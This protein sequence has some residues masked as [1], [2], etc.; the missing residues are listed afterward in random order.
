MKNITKLIFVTL[1]LSG[2]VQTMQQMTFETP[3]PEQVKM[4][5]ATA[6]TVL[7]NQ[8]QGD[9]ITGIKNLIN[10]AFTSFEATINEQDYPPLNALIVAAALPITTAIATV[11]RY[12]EF[13]VDKIQEA[14]LPFTILGQNP[15]LTQILNTIIV[16]NKALFI[17]VIGALHPFFKTLQATFEEFVQN[18]S[19]LASKEFQ[20]TVLTKLVKTIRDQN[21]QQGIINAIDTHAHQIQSLITEIEKVA[22]QAVMMPTP[23]KIG[24]PQQKPHFEEEAFTLIGSQIP[25]DDSVPPIQTPASLRDIELL[26]PNSPIFGIGD[27]EPELLEQKRVQRSGSSSSGKAGQQPGGTQITTSSGT[28]QNLPKGSSK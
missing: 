24:V 18:P 17:A 22:P 21:I 5:L 20:H 13:Y 26:D 23:K 25:L 1:L 12:S 8:G 16:P 11:T 2:Y 7:K 4:G 3:S 19:Q 10:A 28:I 6:L 15:A 27:F 14:L 9:A